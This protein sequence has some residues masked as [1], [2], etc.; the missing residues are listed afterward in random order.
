M[1][2][3]LGHF[4]WTKSFALDN[5]FFWKASTQREG[6]CFQFQ[7]GQSNKQGWE[8]AHLLFALSFKIAQIKERPWLIPSGCSWQK[9]D[10][11]GIAQVPLNK[12]TEVAHDKRATW[13]NRSCHSQ[14]R[15]ILLK[16][17]EKNCIICMCLTVFPPIYAN[18]WIAPIAL[19][20]VTLF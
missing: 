6:M 16:K 12:I 17:I 15:A 13:A 3:H 8:F 10:C 18:E 2:E 1:C 9:S 19:C 7:G 4:T 11:E 20:S 5:T 14:K